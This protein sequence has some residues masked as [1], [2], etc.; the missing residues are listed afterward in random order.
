MN[1]LEQ[2]KLL[3]T[4]KHVLDNHQLY[5]NLLPYTHH[6]A[7]VANVL[8]VFEIDDEALEVAA[9]LHDIVE[10]TS[11]KVRD[12]E[13]LFGEEIAALVYAVT[14]EPGENRT[15]RNALTYPK[16][17]EAGIKA[18]ILKLADRIAN[19][20]VGGS[21]TKRYVKEHAA[22]RHGIYLGRFD[23]HPLYAKALLMQDWLDGLLERA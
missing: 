14:S 10:D 13:E 1:L 5:G 23:K 19:V 20:E 3:A 4:Q 16:I 11:V 12:I 6:L 9:W 21:M 17:R 18:V 22:F 8:R 15:I 7:A 2:A